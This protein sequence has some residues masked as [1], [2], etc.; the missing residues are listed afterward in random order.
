MK[1]SDMVSKIQDIMIEQFAEPFS[2][3]ESSRLLQALEDL[4]MVPPEIDSGIYIRS[5]CANA[6][7]NEWE[8]E[9]G[10]NT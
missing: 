5:E 2:K 10:Q 9:D 6:M 3:E 1:R 8:P 4:G 7:V